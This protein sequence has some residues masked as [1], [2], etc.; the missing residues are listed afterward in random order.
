MCSRKNG[1]IT[2]LVFVEDKPNAEDSASSSDEEDE[3]KTILQ[4]VS[5]NDRLEQVSACD[6][7]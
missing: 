7:M 3:V 2:S 1:G 4:Q 6:S 5:A